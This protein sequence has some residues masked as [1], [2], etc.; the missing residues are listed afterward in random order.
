[1]NQIIPEAVYVPKDET[2]NLWAIDYEKLIPVL[3]RAM[4]EQE[5]KIESQQQTINE[6]IHRMEKL[7]NIKDKN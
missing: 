4:Q 7:E 1:L 5:E 3:T 2:I 6:L